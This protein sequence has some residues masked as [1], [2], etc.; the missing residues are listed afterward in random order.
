MVFAAYARQVL[1]AMGLAVE[2]RKRSKTCSLESSARTAATSVPP[3]RR[4]R[5]CS[6]ARSADTGRSSGAASRRGPR[7][8]SHSRRMG[9]SMAPRLPA[10]TGSKRLDSPDYPHVTPSRVLAIRQKGTL[11]LNGA[12][13]TT[14]TTDVRKRRRPGW[15]VCSSE[16]TGTRLSPAAARLAMF[17]AIR[18]DIGV[19]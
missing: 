9:L 11:C 8:L 15:S 2:K 1:G 16:P 13:P 5:A 6:S 19:C 10:Q 3:A 14:R 7:P 4:Y 18:Q 17:T 12:K